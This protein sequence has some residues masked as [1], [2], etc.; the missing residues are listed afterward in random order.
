M[1]KVEASIETLTITV[2]QFLIN[3]LDEPTII[4]GIIEGYEVLFD[5][6]NM[7]RGLLKWKEAEIK[8]RW[9]YDEEEGIWLEKRLQLFLKRHTTNY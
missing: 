4:F 7:I 6:F 5:R 2:K 9:F 3:L 1:V 8:R